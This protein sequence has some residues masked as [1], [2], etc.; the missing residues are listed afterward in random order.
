MSWFRRR[1][2]ARLMQQPCPVGW[3]AILSRNV[4][5]WKGLPP[6]DRAELIGHMQ[7][8]MDEKRFEGAGGLELTDEIR[9]TIA[10]HACLLL[11]HRNATYYPGLVT[12]LVY[13]GA[14][15]APRTTREATGMVTTGME[16]RL[17]ESWTRG[18]V[19]LAWD[20]VRRTASDVVGCR[21]VA[22]HEFAHQLDA[23]DGHVEGAPILPERS[24]LVSWARVL[25]QEF[26]RLQRDTAQ[27]RATVLDRYGATN[28]GEFF[29]VATECFFTRPRVLRSKHPELYAELAS[30]YRQDP[31]QYVQ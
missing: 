28:P 16:P 17:G 2:R 19:V 3:E 12:I 5:Q 4:P 7:V 25:G 22:L 11:L 29:A 13:P 26:E 21:N 20:A 9:V 6:E 1:R 15:L 24:M 30:F 10:A 14:Y 31:A 23:E 8:F 18:V 27:G